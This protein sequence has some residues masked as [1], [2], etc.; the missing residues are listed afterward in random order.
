MSPQELKTRFPNA[1]K[2]LLAANGE[3]QRARTKPALKPSDMHGILKPEP[4]KP[5][6]SQSMNKTE[7]EYY[8]KLLVLYDASEIKWEG[9][10]LRLANRATYCPDFAVSFPD[11]RIEFHEVKGA[12]IFPK[13]LVKLRIA[14]ELF[15]HRFFL[16]QKKKTGWEVQEIPKRTP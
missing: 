10:V 1:S 16:A 6:R 12:Y 4:V 5:R 3:E 2:S 14:A 13:A 8:N 7:R 15:P 11:G 9:Y